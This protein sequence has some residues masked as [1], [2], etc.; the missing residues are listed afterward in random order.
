MKRI[1]QI[2]KEMG[3][4]SKAMLKLL[5]KLGYDAA[6]P[7][8]PMGKE[9]LDA[10]TEYLKKDKEKVKNIELE[11]RKIRARIPPST[12]EKLKEKQLREKGRAEQKMRETMTKIKMGERTKRYKKEIKEE[13]VEDRSKQILLAELTSVRELAD[14]LR[15]DPLDLIAK[16]IK[17]GLNVT[18]NHRLDFE[19]AATI[20]SEYGCEATLSATYEEEE[21]EELSLA[22]EPRY[23]IVTVMGHV[24]HGKTTLLDYIRHTNVVES[25]V[26]R[27]TQHIVILVIAANEGAKPQTVEAINHAKDAAVP[28]I[29]AITKSDLPEANPDEAEKQ[30][31]DYSVVTEKYGGDVPCCKIS[32]KTGDGIR[33]LLETILIMAELL[34]LKTNTKVEAKATIIETK[35]DKGRG[36][37]ATAIIHQGIL[38]IGDPILAGNTS[39]KVR[40]L[41]NEWGKSKN[42]ALPSDP[43]QIV[44]LDD[45]PQ[46]GDIL[47]VVSDEREAREIC[48]MRKM[49]IRDEV[50]KGRKPVIEDMQLI[51][52]E[53]NK[54]LKIIIKSDVAGSAEALSDMLQNLNQEEIKISIVHQAAGEINESDILLA[55]ASGAMVLGFNAK[56]NANAYQM[57]K[58][59]NVSIRTYNIIYNAIEDIQN[60]LKGLIP[61]KFEEYDIGK[62]EVKQ[63]FKI[64]GVGFVIGC[65][66]IQGKVVRGEKVRVKR[67]NTVVYE[68]IIDSLKRIKDPV[69]E[70]MEGIE[71]GIGFEESVKLEQGDLIE[72]YGI[73]EVTQK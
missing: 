23:P 44:G 51:G 37:I 46:V 66:V 54:E 12:Y 47:R 29:V 27:I 70:V 10:C 5:K 21:V 39:G 40:A 64:S 48:R 9:M 52:M 6:S 32:A 49:S 8:A 16:C 17:L 58:E 41:F 65:L 73:K 26:G 22:T 33:G 59:K 61:P 14:F 50:A 28:I 69:K 4:S 1:Y 34:E 43:I 63:V 7:M 57:A 15:T 72:V 3:I 53:K 24:D 2:A 19:T 45:I 36:P 30:L 20:A 60:T 67:E 38:K 25:E 18:I 62:A 55:A 13:V 71:C 68:G 31:L 11:K 42:K 35:L 56:E